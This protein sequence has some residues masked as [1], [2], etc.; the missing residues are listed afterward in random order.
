MHN[1]VEFIWFLIL[2]LSISAPFDFFVCNLT[3]SSPLLEP[4]RRRKLNSKMN[5]EHNSTY[6]SSVYDT[7]IKTCEQ[8]LA[9]SRGPHSVYLTGEDNVSVHYSIFVL[10][11]PGCMAVFMC[12]HVLVMWREKVMSHQ[13][14]WSWNLIYFFNEVFAL[15]D[16][17]CKPVWVLHRWNVIG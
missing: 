11:K 12:E 10:A 3:F 2:C 9:C 14:K 7:E 8:Q 17:Y 1:V 6:P 13:S 5:L 16:Y 4:G 15:G